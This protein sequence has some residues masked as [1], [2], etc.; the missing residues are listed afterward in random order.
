[1]AG[2]WITV[3]AQDGGDFKAYMAVPESGSG[4]A[5]VLLQEIFGVN[6]HMRDVADDYAEEGYVVG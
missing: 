4:P 3:T 1:M 5:I 6:Q 2:D